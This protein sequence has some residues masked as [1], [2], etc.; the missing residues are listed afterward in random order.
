MANKFTSR[1]RLQRKLIVAAAFFMGLFFLLLLFKGS[2]FSWFLNRQIEALNKGGE[3]TFHIEKA[4]LIGF[5]KVEFTSISLCKNSGDS[6]A[7]IKN[8]EV[9]IRP[10]KLLSRQ[11]LFKSMALSSGFIQYTRLISE[12]ADT[13]SQVE[14]KEETAQDEGLPWKLYQAFERYFPS[15]IAISDFHFN[16]QDALGHVGIAM[17]SIQ[18]NQDLLQG[19]IVLKDDQSAQTWHV[20]GRLDDGIELRAFAEEKQALP[21]LYQRFGLDLRSDTV[22]FSLVKTGMSPVGL[23]FHVSASILELQLFHPKLSSDTLGFRRLA[24][25]MDLSAGY[26]YIH[27]D[28]SSR[29]TVN[30]VEGNFALQAP[31]T[32]SGNKYGLLIKT[33]QL[34]AQN[35]FNSLPQGAFDDTRGIKASGELA[36]T[37]RFYMDG[38]KPNDLVF[39]AYFTKKDFK[40]Q[41]YGQS[42]LNKMSD[43][44]EH[45]VYEN[46]RAYRSFLVGP[47]NP[48]FTPIED[49]PQKLIQA[50]LV[51][52]DPS[53]FQHGGFIIE[54]FRESIAT[55]YK[56]E[57]FKRGG[58]TISMQLIK[59][60]FLSRKKTV[61]R[62]MEEALLVWL[63]EGQHLTSKERMMEVYLNII[64]WGPDI[65]GIFEASQFYFNKKPAELSFPECIYLANIIPRPKKFKYSFEKD[66]KLR[67]YMVDLQTFILRRMLSKQIIT[68]SDTLTYNPYIRLQGAAKNMVVEVDSSLF[69]SLI[70]EEAPVL[71]II[72]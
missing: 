62:K 34:P 57:S 29:F 48:K 3:Y 68:P 54:A 35:F 1:S 15:Q 38:S 69:D 51:S 66:G 33:E 65:Y 58:S 50:I 24:T 64:E 8:L 72:P 9:V 55:N 70:I 53:F 28:S 7:F 14:E 41:Q 6:L 27:I 23:R 37:L 32:R 21:A 67:Q 2:L 20:S 42:R 16:Y 61:F 43:E 47:N 63:I 39:D 52:E 5:S 60:V 4:E 49:V 22:A 18:G 59:N 31:L 19:I 26:G 40:I 10:A 56:A 12:P 71:E 25:E 44:F 45:T 11:Q 30:E 17:D 46:D 13:T 36:Y